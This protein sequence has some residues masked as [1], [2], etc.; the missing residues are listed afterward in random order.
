MRNSR[1]MAWLVVG[2][3]CCP[4]LRSQGR[5]PAVVGPAPGAATAQQH[6]GPGEDEADNGAVHEVA[7]AA[8]ADLLCEAAKSHGAVSLLTE[9]LPGSGPQRPAPDSRNR[10]WERLRQPPRWFWPFRRGVIPQKRFWSLSGRK[11][12]H[13]GP[14]FFACWRAG[15]RPK[16]KWSD[17][18]PPVEI[19]LAVAVGSAA[20]GEQLELD[21][22]PGEPLLFEGVAANRDGVLHVAAALPPRHV[23]HH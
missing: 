14:L 13:T 5:S 17:I 21:G 2:I 11:G 7:G 8:C 18:G 22:L 10:P 1:S 23:N 9:H 19:P 3:S 6:P 16:G 20:P 4:I 12:G 15:V